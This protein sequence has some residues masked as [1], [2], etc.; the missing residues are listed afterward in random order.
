MARHHSVMEG[1]VDE[2]AV[3]ATVLLVVRRRTVPKT[4][5]SSSSDSYT[6][7]HISLS[8]Y[9]HRLPSLYDMERYKLA[10]VQKIQQHFVAGKMFRTLVMHLS[11]QE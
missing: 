7:Q 4:L 9:H 1:E 2:D 10:A 6:P 8:P 3:A 11:A 5:S